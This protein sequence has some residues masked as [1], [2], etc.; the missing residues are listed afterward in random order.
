MALAQRG[1]ES[2]TLQA[3][4]W[5]GEGLGVLAA[6]LSSSLGGINTATTRYL[7]S[8][9]DPVTFVALRFGLGFLLLLP[10]ALALRSGW[11]KGRDWLG[12][13]LLGILFFAVFQGVFNLSLEYTSA[14]RGALALM[15]Q[16]G[17]GGS[18]G[19]A[20]L[21]SFCDSGRDFRRAVVFHQPQQLSGLGGHGFAAL[22]GGLQKLC[23]CRDRGRQ[24]AR[25][26][27]RQ[28]F[29]LAGQ[30]GLQMSG[31][32]DPLT[33]VVAA[34]VAGDLGTAVEQAHGGG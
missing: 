6:I 12:V 24:P 16:E 27:G 13:A 21:E 17:H 29:P 4:R 14:A 34:A 7:M 28:G 10:I 1:S 23:R 20:P 9:T 26:G 32:V 22:E 30:Q 5:R 3:G 8:A 11:P 19:C 31:I 15:K 18:A 2:E 33:S 25:S